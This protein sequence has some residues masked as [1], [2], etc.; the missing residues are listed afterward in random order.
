MKK[1]V[2]IMTLFM[3]ILMHESSNWISMSFFAKST[4]A[5]CLWTF[6][7]SYAC[8]VKTVVLYFVL[9]SWLKLLN[10]R[11]LYKQH[12]FQLTLSVA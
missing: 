2:T 6:K 9:N 7:W 1:A 5:D 3:Y 4:I 11:F 8:F 12:F 10:T